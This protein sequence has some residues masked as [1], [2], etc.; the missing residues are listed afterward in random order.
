M[1]VFVLPRRRRAAH[2]ASLISILAKI[3]SCFILEPATKNLLILRIGERGHCE[4][5]ESCLSFV[6]PGCGVPPFLSPTAVL[7]EYFFS[8]TRFRPGYSRNRCGLYVL[9]RERRGECQQSLRQLSTRDSTLA[10]GDWGSTRSK[11][12]G[13][14]YGET[15]K[16]RATVF[17]L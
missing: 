3:F 15:G 7:S 14:R 1:S 9:F 13:A 2:A 6:V 16:T 17:S 10:M 12:K 11:T 5:R 8:R 4:S